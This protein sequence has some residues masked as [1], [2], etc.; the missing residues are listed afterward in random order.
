MQYISNLVR[1]FFRLIP[2]HRRSFIKN[3]IWQARICKG[4]GL[5]SLLV[6]TF[7]GTELPQNMTL[8]Q[9]L[10]PKLPVLEQEV[11]PSTNSEHLRRTP[12]QSLKLVFNR[13]CF[14][15]VQMVAIFPY[16]DMYFCILTKWTRHLGFLI[17]YSALLMKTWRYSQ[18][19]TSKYSCSGQ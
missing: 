10:V 5:K 18:P 6:G 15:F 11:H 8:V 13:S 7:V 4:T 12:A 14:L 3:I 2:A 16:L 9:H 1:F 17:T 19:T